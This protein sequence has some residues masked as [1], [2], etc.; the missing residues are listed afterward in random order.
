MN[1]PTCAIVVLNYNGSTLLNQFLE[2]VVIAAKRATICDVR[3]V[4]LDNASTDDSIPW[5]R[6]HFHSVEVFSA[7]S[8]RYLY[9]YNWVAGILKDDLL[10]LL[11]NDIEM[12]PDCL[13]PLFET[14]LNDPQVFSVTPRMY[15]MDRITP[16]SGRWRGRFVRGLLEPKL[17]NT[18]EGIAPTLFP[19]GGAMLVRR[20]DFLTI[21]GF[22]ELY[23]PVYW[24]DVDVGYRAWKRNRPSLCQP[25]SIMYHMGSASIMLDPTYAEHKSAKIFRNVWLFTWRNVVNPRILGANLYWTARH[26]TALQRRHERVLTTAYRQAFPLIRTAL[27]ARKRDDKLRKLSDDNILQ[28]V[29]L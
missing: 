18:N 15:Y 19:C 7:P 1:K 21:G 13:D 4:L 11:N 2:S 5:T 24:E 25:A 8:N 27:V 12:E 10:L 20:S 28:C 23:Y 16:N 29:N 6:T 17:T 22:D 3:V 14:L 9:S 26:Y